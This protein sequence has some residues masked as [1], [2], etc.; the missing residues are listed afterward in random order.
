MSDDVDKLQAEVERLARQLKELQEFDVDSLAGRG[1]KSRKR[2]VDHGKF[3]ASYAHGEVRT[4]V[5]TTKAETGEITELVAPVVLPPDKALGVLH[6]DRKPA[7][8]WADQPKT[9]ELAPHGLTHRAAREWAEANP[10]NPLN[11]R[12]EGPTKPVRKQMT[13]LNKVWKYRNFKQCTNCDSYDTWESRT[14]PYAVDLG[15]RQT[16]SEI[17][18]QTCGATDIEVSDNPP[19]HIGSW[20]PKKET[21]KQR[22]ERLQRKAYRRERTTYSLVQEPK[23]VG[24]LAKWF[25]EVE[26][27]EAIDVPMLE[28]QLR[29]MQR[30]NLVVLE[31]TTGKWWDKQ[32]YD[33]ERSKK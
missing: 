29:Q 33:F 14:D 10:G 13:R 19:A 2:A 16:H 26:R 32:D 23:T 1:G 28:I 6:D 5:Q 4:I 8:H 31:K 27:Y 22:V 17:W 12:D 18:C 20:V 9:D 3:A 30:E 21:D 24:H 25:R 11:L 15:P 7:I